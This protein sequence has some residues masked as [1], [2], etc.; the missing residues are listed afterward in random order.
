MLYGLK[1]HLCRGLFLVH[2]TFHTSLVILLWYTSLVRGYFRSFFGM[3]LLSY[4]SL[5]RGYFRSF[6]G[7]GLLS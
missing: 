2:P 7:M 5:V 1:R 6:F 4:T 3:G